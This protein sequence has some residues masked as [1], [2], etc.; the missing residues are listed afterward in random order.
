MVDEHDKYLACQGGQGM[1][2]RGEGKR[3]LGAARGQVGKGGGVAAAACI[4]AA[5]HRLVG[6]GWGC[7]GE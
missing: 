7:G 5:C 4:A 1:R 6:A 3:E 2:G